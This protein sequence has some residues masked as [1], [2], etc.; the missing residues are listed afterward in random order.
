MRGMLILLLALALVSGCTEGGNVKLADYRLIEDVQVEYSEMKDYVYSGDIVDAVSVTYPKPYL[1]LENSGDVPEA[2]ELRIYRDGEDLYRDYIEVAPGEHKFDLEVGPV[3]LW[4]LR[5][6]HLERD[7]PWRLISIEEG[8][9]QTVGFEIYKDG[10]KIDGK[11]QIVPLG[12]IPSVEITRDNVVVSSS[13]SRLTVYARGSSASEFLLN[14]RMSNLTMSLGSYVEG[15][16]VDY[17]EGRFSI[18]FES[19]DGTYTEEVCFQ[20]DALE[21]LRKYLQPSE[22]SV[23]Y[24]DNAYRDQDPCLDDLS[25]DGFL[26]LLVNRDAILREKNEIDEANGDPLG[27]RTRG[28][29]S[30][31]PEI[32]YFTQIEYPR[33]ARFQVK[34]EFTASADNIER[35][36]LGT[37]VCNVQNGGPKCLLEK[38]E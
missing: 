23:V 37:V 24:I 4:A 31:L 7:L 38:I 5:P 9:I 36:V 26:K 21:L 34:V 20:D 35:P 25:P 1:V 33:G 16:D 14:P 8:G 29:E 28:I 19:K 18:R 15:D 30:V 13:N 27:I 12:D 2:V 11:E 32:P 10:E 22:F 6:E 17:E 3:S